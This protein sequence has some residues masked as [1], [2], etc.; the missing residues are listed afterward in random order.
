VL[1][2]GEQGLLAV[3]KQ[4][5]IKKLVSKLSSTNKENFRPEQLT[6]ILQFGK[7]AFPY[8]AEA[9]KNKQIDPAFGEHLLDKLYDESL[10]DD[11][12]DLTGHTYDVARG[13]AKRLVLKN[14]N[15]DV[16][17][18]LITNLRNPNSY[19]RTSSSE[20]L[21]DIK[22][23]S[24]V[25]D[26]IA[27]YQESETDLKLTLLSVL[28]KLGGDTASNAL[29]SALRNDDWRVRINAVRSLGKMKS[30]KSV[31][32]LIEILNEKD[33]QMKN[34]AL[35]ALSEIGDTRA[36]LP[37]LA[38]L[39]DEDLII[40]QKAIDL[41]NQ[42][43]D[44]QIIPQVLELMR[45]SDD[46]NTR[47]SAIEIVNKMKDPKTGEA[48]VRAMKDSDWWV[49][50]IAIDALVEIK[51]ENIIRILIAM[52][53]D[54]DENIRRS[55]VE[56]FNEVSDSSAVEPLIELLKDKDWWVR[57][58]AV[59]ALGRLKDPRAIE[60]LRELIGDEEVNREIAKAFGEIGGEAV[61]NPL[62][63]LLRE[64]NRLVRIEA[65]KAL[66]MIKNEAVISE[67]KLALEDPEEEV[68]SEAAKALKTLTGKVF[69]KK[70]E[71]PKEQPE[72]GKV[73][74]K[75]APEGSLL[76]EAI[77]V[78]DICNSTW[79][80][81]KYGNQFALNLN[82]ILT[83]AVNPIAK[84]ENLNFMKSTGDGFLIT[85]P[86]IKNAV[87]FVLDLQDK[88]AKYNERVDESKMIEL[89]FAINFGETRVDANEDRLGVATN[90]TFRVEGIKSKDLI[91]VN[92][93]IKKDQMPDVDRILITENVVEE[94]DKI[95]G[96]KTKLLGIFELKGISGLHRIYELTGNQ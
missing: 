59:S 77:V 50:N 91:E 16:I 53:N 95:Q 51:G 63:E 76:T 33:P 65:I 57:E 28:G 96:V 88:I 25:S 5:K 48:L 2:L 58:K 17:Q 12:L 41:I 86:K 49:R 52:L 19:L 60:P 27:L 85:F 79:I 37:A 23:Q 30:I 43:G 35:D 64:D 55:A 14:K 81:N 3:F 24:C 74:G 54:S 44:S 29:I 13:I 69:K 72:M 84:R 34:S 20:L 42:V 92:G 89:R 4:H 56:F 93:G 45:D 21:G 78:L 80:A 22:D 32:S 18:K 94:A 9:L 7:S 11:L 87:Q 75:K 38:L 82:I 10:T 66:S 62:F 1:E 61:I 39:K 6:P 36:A 47:R 26:L 70:E 15:K 90:M 73:I 40:R 83:K 8:V 46:V 71:R 68:K 67:I 31:D